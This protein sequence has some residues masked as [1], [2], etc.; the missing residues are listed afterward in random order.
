MSEEKREIF[1]VECDREF[2]EP[3]RYFTELGMDPDDREC[4]CCSNGHDVEWEGKL[5]RD[6]G[7]GDGWMM[8]GEC[9][10]CGITGETEVSNRLLKF[11]TFDSD[12]YATV[13]AE[14]CN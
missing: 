4:D 11:Y 3:E 8:K 13:E 7:C 6:N 12:G 10:E 5:D 1:C 9:K 2:Y 14:T